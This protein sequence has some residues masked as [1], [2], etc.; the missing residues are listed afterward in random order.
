MINNV[1]WQQN[2]LWAKVLRIWWSVQHSSAA[3]LGLLP[4]HH[5]MS[6]AHHSVSI[7]G[8]AALSLHIAVPVF[9]SYLCSNQNWGH[10]M[11]H[12]IWHSHF[13]FPQT[14]FLKCSEWIWTHCA[15]N[16]TVWIWN[17]LY[18]SE[19]IIQIHHFYSLHII[20]YQRW[21]VNKLSWLYWWLWD[22]HVYSLV[23]RAR[24]R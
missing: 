11:W 19:L 10:N 24:G 14:P 17:A 15:L 2:Q 23:A 18:R 16:S 6:A 8:A 21:F 13:H 22:I 12:L 5:D 4:A 7:L 9:S 1:I 3:L 20:I